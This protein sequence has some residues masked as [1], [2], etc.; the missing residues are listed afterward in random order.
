[1]TEGEED[2]VY[3]MILALILVAGFTMPAAAA[4][5]ENECVRRFNVCANACGALGSTPNDGCLG[6]CLLDGGCEIEGG[7]SGQSRAPDSTLPDS[8]LP[9]SALPGDRMPTGSLPDSRM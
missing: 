6:S 9:Q 2:F 7:A 4:E 5:S 3:R 1:M 8:S